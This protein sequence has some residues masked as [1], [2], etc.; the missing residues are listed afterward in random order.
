MQHKRGWIK[1]DD[2][3]RDYANKDDD[4]HNKGAYINLMTQLNKLARHSKG[5]SVHKSMQQYYHHVHLFCLFLADYFS[6]KTLANIHDKHIVAYVIERQDEGK[7]ASTIKNDLAAI[8]Y[9]HDQIPN[10]RYRISDNQK[11]KEKYPEFDLE[12]R[13]FGG[14][15]RRATEYEYQALVAL[16]ANSKNPKLSYIIQLARE[17]GLRVHEAV[18]V[19]RANAKKA[20]RTGLLTVKGKGGLIRNVPINSTASTILKSAMSGIERGHKL[21]VPV[22]LKTHQVI[23]QIQDFVRNNRDKVRD[24]FNDRAEGVEITMHSFRHNYAKEQFEY[25]LEEGHE[26]EDAKRKVSRLIGH[27]R[28]DVTD[29][30]LA[31]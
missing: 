1:T 6:L 31:D 20:L 2:E 27:H 8:R 18:K 21:F 15:N 17:L 25:F 3:I 12:R 22:H 11:L 5:I 26:P 19:D 24:P 10:T 9:F 23:Q 30:Y 28:A 29:I 13:K 7:S 16:A 14:V 4:L